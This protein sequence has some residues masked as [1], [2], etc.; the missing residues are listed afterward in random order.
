MS[1]KKLNIT[2]INKNHKNFNEKKKVVFD[3]GY[4]INIDVKFKPT[5]INKLITDFQDQVEYANN[6][7]IN[8]SDINVIDYIFFLVIK[9]FTD[10]KIPDDSLEKQI[11]IFYKLADSDYYKV[12]MES[13][14]QNELGKIWEKIYEIEDFYK[15]YNENLQKLKDEEE[16]DLENEDLI[17]DKMI[18]N[19]IDRQDKY[20]GD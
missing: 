2:A 12:I 5:K 7:N 8:I 14:D 1:E 13:F 18:N 9:H 17:G 20:N 6:N 10:L 3:D 16:I 4:Y 15:M 11:N 19:E